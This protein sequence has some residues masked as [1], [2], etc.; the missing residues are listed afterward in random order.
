MKKVLNQLHWRNFDSEKPCDYDSELGEIVEYDPDWCYV[1]YEYVHRDW[2]KG[3]M[4][5][6]IYEGAIPYIDGSFKDISPNTKYKADAKRPLYWC[7]ES[8]VQEFLL[9]TLKKKNDK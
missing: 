9:S 7:L 8:E 2:L 4:L 1:I 3:Q 6:N 5:S